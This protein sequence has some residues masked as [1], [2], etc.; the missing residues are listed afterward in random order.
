[1]NGT[2]NVLAIETAKDAG[3]PRLGISAT[4]PKLPSLGML[5]GGY[6]NGK[7]LAEEA[8]RKH[9]PETGG[10]LRPSIIYGDRQV[11]GLHGGG[12]AGKGH[13]MPP[14]SLGGQGTLHGKG[15]V[16][17]I[18]QFFTSN[19]VMRGLFKQRLEGMLGIR[20][21]GRRSCPDCTTDSLCSLPCRVVSSSVTL[22]LGYVFKPVESLLVHC[23]KSLVDLP[24]IGGLLV[25][26]VSAEAV[27]R[28]AIAAATD[29]SF[30]A[31]VAGVD[32]IQRYK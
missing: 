4:I 8:V 25:P 26:P 7:A 24:V 28:A 18:A 15:G 31:G 16:H 11:G 5:V 32:V 27:A 20:R 10:F 29:S 23:P 2:A 21:G 19:G 30:S 14:V 6:I 9:Y 22:P 13:A 12:R 3:V 1:M 17:C